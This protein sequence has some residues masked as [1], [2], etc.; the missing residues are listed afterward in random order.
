[1]CYI[2]LQFKTTVISHGSIAVNLPIMKTQRLSF[3]FSIYRS[4]KKSSGPPR[5]YM[6]TCSQDTAK[7]V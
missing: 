6:A 2:I 7:F 1:M 3:S 5:V 4:P